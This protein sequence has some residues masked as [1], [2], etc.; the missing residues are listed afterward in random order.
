M[1]YALV[2]VAALLVSAMALY[3]GFGLG[4]LLMPIFALFFPVPVAVASTA[5]VHLASNL[6]RLGFTGR[7]ADWRVVA[8]F[9]V[10]GAV[11][12]IGGALLLTWVSAFPPLTA[13]NLG[14]REFSVTAVKLLIAALI[15]GFAVLELAPAF[16]TWKLDRRYLPLGGAVSGFFGGLSGH[17]GALRSAVLLGTGLNPAAFIGTGAVTAFIVDLSRVAVYSPGVLRESFSRTGEGNVAL[18][19]VAIVAAFLGNYLGSRFL[20]RVTIGFIRRLVGV[21]L[22][23]L[24]AA[25]GTGLV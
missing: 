15:A 9:G 17:Q 25:L 18:V 5:V 13:Y 24:A 14:S 21:L 8:A 11:A 4:T 16:A 1:E 23:V 7:Q 19:G 22:I 12:A 6:F 3:S 2:S 20:A 10:P